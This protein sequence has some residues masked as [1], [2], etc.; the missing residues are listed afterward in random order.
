MTDREEGPLSA[1]EILDRK[2][3]R[4]EILREIARNLP[5]RV[6]HWPIPDKR[7][8]C[9]SIV[10]DRVNAVWVCHYCKAVAP[11]AQP[12]TLREIFDEKEGPE[13]SAYHPRRPC[14]P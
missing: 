8:A 1:Q 6:W 11:P 13:I 2:L 7:C 5:N 10:F 4:D 3:R 12:K 14:E 9:G